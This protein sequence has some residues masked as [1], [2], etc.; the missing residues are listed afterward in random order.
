MRRSIVACKGLVGLLALFSFSL[1]CDL[2]PARMTSD[3]VSPSEVQS[4]TLLSSSDD[5]EVLPPEV[6]AE[7]SER[8]ATEAPAD[9]L[10]PADFPWAD[11]PC[12]EERT[13]TLSVLALPL[14]PPSDVSQVII[15][16]DE[17]PAMP[18]E[19]RFEMADGAVAVVPGER[20]AVIDM[21]TFGFR[22]AAPAGG[23][24]ERFLIRSGDRLLACR[25]ARA[26]R[27]RTPAWNAHLER[28]YSLW[29]SRLLDISFGD[30][31]DSLSPLL[32]SPERN[33]LHNALGFGEDE[34]ISPVSLAP[35][36]ADFPMVL[37]A[38]FAWKLG[39]PFGLNGIEPPPWW[40]PDPA[41][42][43][44]PP[45]PPTTASGERPPPRPYLWM[46]NDPM[47]GL[48]RPGAFQNHMIGLMSR[49]SWGKLRAD[50][51]S[52]TSTLYPVPLTREALRPGTVYLDPFSHVSMVAGW[53]DAGDGKARLIIADA[54]PTN[55]IAIHR[56]IEGRLVYRQDRPA[57]FRWFRPFGREPDQ[58]TWTLLGSG[59]ITPARVGPRL[60][61]GRAPRESE[62]SF[63]ERIE[64]LQDPNPRNP[65][66]ALGALVEAFQATL[67]ERAKIVESGFRVRVD[68]GQEI[69]LPPTARLMFH[70]FGDWQAW[71]TP[72][73]DLRLLGFMRI[74]S[75]FPEAVA[76]NP[77]RYMLPPDQS[78]QDIRSRL[79]TAREQM[80]KA[81]SFT[82]RRSD[83]SEQA[84][85]LYEVFQRRTAFE[86]GYN[87]NDCPEIRWGAPAGS[88]EISTCVLR[89]SPQQRAL[90][91]IYRSEFQEGYGCE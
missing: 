46:L 57:G 24:L 79:E 1:G 67:S 28:L 76:S 35:D 18:L 23:K 38:Y 70:G 2:A 34:P 11:R 64:T 54:Q 50:W 82:Y 91:E 33:L 66:E 13:E 86:I 43:V 81:R 77:A 16:A 41:A 58:K 7:T 80:L 53:Q 15:A 83:G 21:S 78:S 17:A 69:P 89:V 49:H 74:L 65:E 29:V 30:L 90:M 45:T 44:G 60:F 39:L 5:R 8:T 36:C 72:C 27:S 71:S 48:L 22:F 52:S 75:H 25:E 6:A 19:A 88:D 84:L 55:Y 47:K 4:E 61:H 85:T 31:I 20:I 40:P 73:R 42:P 59:S 56:Y 62:S 3:G 32:R 63:R 51:Y 14:R 9:P 87:P 26:F 37:R 10:P 12:P 68:G